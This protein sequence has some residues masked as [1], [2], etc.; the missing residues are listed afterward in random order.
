MRMDNASRAQLDSI[1]DFE[2]RRLKMKFHVHMYVD[3]PCIYFVTFSDREIL[4]RLQK[5]HPIKYDDFT[6]IP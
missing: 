6:G 4:I 1:V 2:K 3:V 5:K